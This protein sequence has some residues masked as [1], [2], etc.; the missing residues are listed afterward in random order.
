MVIQRSIEKKVYTNVKG[1]RKWKKI[2]ADGSKGYKTIKTRTP[3]CLII[4]S[5]TN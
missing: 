2:I 5:A 4:N 3:T 1:I